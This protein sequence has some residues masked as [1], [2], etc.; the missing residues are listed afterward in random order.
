MIIDSCSLLEQ[1]TE[2]WLDDS[3]QHFCLRL[4]E[5]GSFTGLPCMLYY[6]DQTEFFPLSLV[7]AASQID[8]LLHA[9]LQLKPGL[10]LRT[11]AAPFSFAPHG[12]KAGL[13][14]LQ[15]HF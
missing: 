3:R 8:L 13:T 12:E 4:P 10:G 14:A 7:A 2:Q 1:F 5:L 9:D 11:S 6:S 15:H